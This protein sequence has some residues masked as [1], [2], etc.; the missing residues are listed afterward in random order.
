MEHPGPE[1]LQE[2]SS[3]ERKL[4]V[5]SGAG[6]LTPADRAEILIVL[7]TD[8]DEFVAQQAREALQYSTNGSFCRSVETQRGHPRSF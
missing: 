6:T 1:I 7:S 3:R 4:A 8:P 2:Q 5:C